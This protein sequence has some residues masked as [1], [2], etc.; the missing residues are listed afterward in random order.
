MNAVK[1]DSWIPEKKA[2]LD[3]IIA[4]CL[5]LHVE[6][7]TTNETVTPGQNIT[8]KLDAINRSNIPVTVQEA[9][10][11]LS[12]DSTKIG[13]A[14]PTNELVTKDLSCKV[15]EN[16]PYSQ[17]Y[18][19]CEPGTLGTFAEDD[20]QLIGLPENPPDLPVEIAL[21]IDGQEIRYTLE[22]K[23]RTVDPVAGELR[24]PLVIAPPVFAKIGDGVLVF[25][26]DQPKPVSVY[27]TAATGAVKGTLK[28]AAPKGWEVNPASVPIDLKGANAETVATFTVKPPNH[29][30]E[31]MLRAIVSTGGRDYS[32]ERVRISYPHIGV[33][34][35]MPPAEV[36][37]VR[38]DI[39]KKGDRIG[40]IP[41]AGDDVPES[42]QQIGYS[43]KVLSEGEITAENLAQFSAVVLGIRAYNTHDRIA[44]WLPELFAYVKAGGVVIV[45]Y[46]TLAELKTEQFGPYPLEISRDRVTDENTEVRILAPNHPIMNV[47]NKITSK[48]FG[49]WVQERG[50]YFP[51]TWDPAW[52][53]ILSSNDPKEKP[54]DGGLLVAKFGKGFFIYTS[55]SWF[56]QL[57]A[58]V[59]GAYRLFAN[60]LSLGK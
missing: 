2:E 51:K 17:P 10:C 54:L 46:N 33:Q 38:A 13:A 59:P 19:L 31:G 4:A 21:Q 28:L 34:T 24:Q 16:T 44:N 1:D 30:S 58:G 27:V 23:Y 48:D 32:F 53:P 45:Q 42:L 25:P 3:Q 7:S 50:L 52:I 41:G 35:L 18:W 29:D 12:G 57:P 20:Q 14:L 9:R 8:I 6:A 49:G 11:L 36:K 55:Y 5:G 26:T 56:R 40:Y 43:V 60:M 15:R 47:P 37:L 39:R 22:G